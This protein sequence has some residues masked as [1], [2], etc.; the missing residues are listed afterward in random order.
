MIRKRE[1]RGEMREKGRER[2]KGRERRRKITR[3]AD[4][5]NKQ[6]DSS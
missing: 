2:K 6:I 5:S 4:S 3:I 1:R